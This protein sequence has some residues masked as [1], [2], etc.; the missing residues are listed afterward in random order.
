MSVASGATA[1]VAEIPIVSNRATTKI[2]TVVV[3]S[4]SAEITPVTITRSKPASFIPTASA[5]S[6]PTV[7]A[8]IIG[9][10][11]RTSKEEV[12]T[13]R[14][15]GVD[16]EMPIT[17]VPVK[18]TIEIGCVYIHTVLPIEK[19]ISE[20]EITLP[21]I[22][23]IEIIVCID[24]EQVV[25]IDLIGGF[26]LLIGEVEFVSHLIGQEQCLPACLLITHCICRDCYSEQSYK[27]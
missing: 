17:A 21:P 3:V 19:H 11:V 1:S 9:I 10:E 18:R 4:H 24:A 8:I 23:A 12:V 7:S 6:S 2:S 5:V 14:I 26:I 27:G 16:T 22:K 13:M 20:I 25:E 15:A